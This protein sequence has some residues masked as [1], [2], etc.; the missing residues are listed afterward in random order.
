MGLDA[1]RLNVAATTRCKR[2]GVMKTVFT[3]GIFCTS[4]ATL[5]AA[6]VTLQFE[7]TVGSPR[8]GVDGPLPP[9]WNAALQPGDIISGMFTYEPYDVASDVNKSVLV[10]PFNFSVAINSHVLTSSQYSI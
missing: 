2:F 4:Y 3:I 7:A 6:P 8:Q 1:H 10:Q 5:S 9:A